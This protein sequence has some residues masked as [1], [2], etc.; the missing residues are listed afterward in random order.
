MWHQLLAVLCH[1]PLAANGL[2]WD[3]RRMQQGL[4]M[5]QGAVPWL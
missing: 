4:F 5:G 2:P 3:R 1:A